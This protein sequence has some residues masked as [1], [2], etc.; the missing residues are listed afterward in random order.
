MSNGV[1]DTYWSNLGVLR[2]EE[3]AESFLVHQFRSFYAELARLKQQVEQG[4][5]VSVSEEESEEG[6]SPNTAA[7][8]QQQFVSMFNTQEQSVRRRGGEALQQRYKL[9]QYA[10]VA[11]A[12]EVFLNLDWR[13][14]DYWYDHLLESRQFDS[15]NA[16][17][18]VFDI[19]DR[20]LQE[21][22]SKV[23]V[24]TVYLYILTLGFEGQYRDTPDA[25]ALTEY[26][27]RLHQHIQ[28]REPQKLDANRPLSMS[29]YRHT[30]DQGQVQLLPNLRWWVGSLVVTGV[31]YL[32]AS[33]TLWWWYT[34]DLMDLA[35]EV[36]LIP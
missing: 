2:E 28:R 30:L 8:L 9:V 25:S 17:V 35:R 13:G 10:M 32:V 1:G 7:D 14:R 33:T 5:Y 23:D 27:E 22:S 11:L 26:R 31:L 29:A 15:Q 20:I 19:I 24:A 21:R 36:L 4:T 3:T 34:D 18:Q 12:D 6:A 16:G